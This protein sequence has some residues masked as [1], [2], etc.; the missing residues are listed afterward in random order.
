MGEANILSTTD[1]EMDGWDRAL[2]YCRRKIWGVSVRRSSEPA[3]CSMM[4]GMGRTH[5]CNGGRRGQYCSHESTTPAA[6]NDALSQA[7]QPTTHNYPAKDRKRTAEATRGRNTIHTGPRS[8][9]PLSR[10]HGR[11]ASPDCIVRARKGDKGYVA[12]FT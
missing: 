3:V 10:E 2:S 4:C 1:G 5:E 7:H 8:R 6:G 12:A 11:L 9:Q